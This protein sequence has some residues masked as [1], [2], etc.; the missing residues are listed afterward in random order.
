MVNVDPS[1]DTICA[2]ATPSGVGGISVIRVSGPKAVHC[3]RQL[4]EFFPERPES[5]TISYGFLRRSS[6]Q[7]KIDEVLLSFFA[8]GRSFT[9]EETVEISCHGSPKICSD[10]IQE[11]VAAGARVANRGEFTYRAFMNG[12]ID[13]VQA[14][15]VHGLVVSQTA[16]E[17]KNLLRQ[18]EGGLSERVVALEKD[19]TRLLAHIEADIDFSTEGLETM[20]SS[21]LLLVAQRIGDEVNSLLAGYQKGRL[22]REGFRVLFL[23]LP[24]VGK[25]SLL[26]LALGE[27]R[28]IVTD[29]PGTTRDLVEGWT[30]LQGVRVSWMDSA[31]LRSGAETVEAMGIERALNEAAR[32]DLLFWVID[33]STELSEDIRPHLRS[34]LNSG[35]D[36]VVLAN[37]VDMVKD[38]DE[39]LNRFREKLGVDLLPISARESKQRCVLLKCIENRLSQLGSANEVVLS[40]TRHFESLSKASQ[41]MTEAISSIE[42]KVSREIVALTLK[43]AL[44]Q[45]QQM[46]GIRYDEQ[47]IDQI[48]K[49]FCLGK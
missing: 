12:R 22:F 15:S 43:E 27:D 28:S 7:E 49:E 21:E 19:L 34:H 10:I 39:R 35:K 11:L 33:F 2:V 36:I 46:L 30:E 1:L 37:K 29:I 16:L 3:I 32:A 8:G 9:G 44:I 13:L 40:Q 20:T 6:D 4:A 23:G 42:K 31:G 14:E 25:S 17:R 18:L 41:S 38:V 24:N 48:F 5:H 47:V 45:V 26:N